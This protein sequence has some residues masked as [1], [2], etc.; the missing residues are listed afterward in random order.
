MGNSDRYLKRNPTSY[1]S[2]LGVRKKDKTVEFVRAS[3]ELSQ[4]AICNSGEIIW[5]KRDAG[6]QWL[7]C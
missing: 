7:R 2:K 6:A 1:P 4:T 3:I 5:K